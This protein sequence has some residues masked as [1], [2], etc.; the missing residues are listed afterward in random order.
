M[1]N[2]F[3]W[4]FIAF[5]HKYRGRILTVSSAGLFAANISYHV[6]PEQT[7]RSLYQGWSKGEPAQLTD[8]L[9]SL[10]QEVLEETHVGSSANYVPFAAYGFHPV[11]AGIPWLPSRC[12]VGIPA[13]YNNTEQNGAGIVDRVLMI[14]GKDVDWS[15]DVGNNLRETLTLSADAQKFSLARE[16]LF[17]QNNSPVLQ[18]FVAP[19]Y[20]SGL[21]LSSV[22]I[23][24]LIGL[25]T[26]PLLLRGLYNVAVAVV[27][28]AGYFLCSDAISQWLD[29]R[30]DR[31]AA[32]LS[33]AYARG[34]LEFYDKILERNRILRNLMGKQ[35]EA[36]YAPS[37]N[38]FPKQYIRMKHAPYTSRRDRIKRSLEAQGE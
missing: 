11:S 23:K 19:A 31:N 5:T 9:Q 24:Q 38:L 18:A 16:V 3:L 10:F 26:G 4:R 8:K 17:A 28:L 21:C 27:G 2:P 6:F 20:L 13:N 15:S 29:Y 14:N 22:A 34:G 1:A 32:A 33:K 12:L 30:S 7:F 35:G 25:Y 37:G 36:M